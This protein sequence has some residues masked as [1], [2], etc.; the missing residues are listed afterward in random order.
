[1]ELTITWTGGSLTINVEDNSY[2]YE[3]VMGDNNLHLTFKT[4]E[5]VEIPLGAVV[6]FQNVSYKLCVP[7]TIKKQSSTSFEI[8]AVFESPQ[9]AL[10]KYTMREYRYNENSGQWDNSTPSLQFSLTATPLEHL[11]MIRDNLNRREGDNTWSIGSCITDKEKTLTF[12]Y[13]NVWDALNNLANEFNTEWRIAGTVLYLGKVEFNKTQPLELSYGKGNGFKSGVGR[14][15]Y[16]DTM[17]IEVLNVQGT[18]R[19]IDPRPFSQGG[20]GSKRL[21]LPGQQAFLYEDSGAFSWN[22]GTTWEKYD[23]ENNV[24]ETLSGYTPTNAQSY[25]TDN[26]GDEVHISAVQQKTHQEANFDG[27]EIYPCRYGVLSNVTTEQGSGG[28]TLYNVFDSS[29]P[30]NLNYNDCQIAGEEMKIVFQSGMLAGR[31][32]AISKYIH[33]TREF[34]LVNEEIDGMVMPEPQ[35]FYPQ[36]GDS[37]AIFG[38]QLPQAYIADFETHTG[39]SF[40]ML[41]AAVKYLHENKNAKYTFSGELDGIFAKNQWATIGGRL[42]IG[43]YVSFTDSNFQSTSVL[44]RI[45]GVKQYINNPYSPEIE[46]SNDSIGSTLISEVRKAQAQEVTTEILNRET[47]RYAKRRF[48]DAKQT[49]EALEKMI[50][51][52]GSDFSNFSGG[53]SPITVQTMQL[54]VGSENLQF[55]FGSIASG[56]FTKRTISATFGSNKIFTIGLSSGQ[57]LMHYTIGQPKTMTTAASTATMKVWKMPATNTIG[58][59]SGE[60]ADKTYYIYAKVKKSDAGTVSSVPS[61]TANNSFVHS[62]TAIAMDDGQE[63]GYY[64]FLVGILNAEIEEDRSFAEMFGYSE[65]LPNRITTDKIISSDG[66]GVVIDLVNGTITGKIRFLSNNTPVDAEQYIGDSVNTAVSELRNYLLNSSFAH[67]LD[68]WTFSGVEIYASYNSARIIG[69]LNTTKNVYQIVDSRINTTETNVFTFSGEVALTS[70]ATKG[71]TNFLLRPY[72]EGSRNGSW[73]GGTF[74]KFTLDGVEYS[75]AT[76]GDAFLNIKGLGFKKF[77][78]TIEVAAGVTGN[79]FFIYAR[80]FTGTLFFRKLKLEKGET[81]TEWSAAPEDVG[82]AVDTANAAKNAVDNLEIGGRNLLLQ[83]ASEWVNAATTANW[84]RLNISTTPLETDETYILSFDAK[85][86]NGTDVFYAALGVGDSSKIIVTNIRPSTTYSRMVVAITN[87][88]EFTSTINSVVISNAV[89]YGKGNANN[90]GTLYVKNIKLEK[91][92]VATDWT[93]AP[94]DV[95]AEIQRQ[96][97][98]IENGTKYLTD[99]MQAARQGESEIEGGLI[100]GTF[101][102]VRKNGQLQAALNGGAPDSE[103][104]IQSGMAE[105]SGMPR[106]TFRV[107]ADGHIQIHKS[108]KDYVSFERNEIHFYAPNSN[109]V[110]ED[111]NVITTDSIGNI[112]TA[113]YTATG[114]GSSSGT[115]TIN[116]TSSSETI[117]DNYGSQVMYS[118][119]SALGTFLLSGT[120]VRAARSGGVTTTKASNMTING[121]SFAVRSADGYTRP[122]IHHNEGD[123]NFISVSDHVWCAVGLYRNGSLVAS[124]YNADLGALGASKT[125]TIPQTTVNGAPAGT[126]TIDIYLQYRQETVEVQFNKGTTG[127]VAVD[128]GALSFTRSYKITSSSSATSGFSTTLSFSFIA[129]K[130]VIYKDG[131]FMSSMNSKWFGVDSN[132]A[133][134]TYGLVAAHCSATDRPLMHLAAGSSTTSATTR[135]TAKGWLQRIGAFDETGARFHKLNMIVLALDLW[136]EDGKWKTS[137]KYPYG[138]GSVSTTTLSTGCVRITHN[139]GHTQYFVLGSGFI[140]KST[141]TSSEGCYVTMY[142]RQANSVDLRLAN[143]SSPD[144]SEAYIVFFDFRTFTV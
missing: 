3:Q 58:P 46:M 119:N 135:F 141:I 22:G 64:H 143:D 118:G 18:D 36:I 89:A 43:E 12:D 25:A 85:T 104:I 42:R 120:S 129:Y 20:Y 6:A 74:K 88:G 126:F 35:A 15:N 40:D 98:E 138:D 76:F 56:V 95:D 10:K 71:T 109:N 32:F 121:F 113:K 29:I 127:H 55:A 110:A 53:I 2:H 111:R 38:I 67:S 30:S 45:I 112:G 97:E 63:S 7:A 100:L 17:P 79:R 82:N 60:L 133:S 48:T 50:E 51:E 136:Y 106:G 8:E 91:G 73:Y 102:G 105:V 61:S 107:Y 49:S 144:N 68:E 75:S 11:K 128:T 115:A 16:G 44:I 92:T 81:A 65:I 99:A 123:A 72:Y 27:T 34:Q 87:S 41:R 78:Y 80:D 62:E 96:R 33:S 13:T 14:T 24:W 137:V 39:A 116:V 70:E 130:D 21:R 94:E 93:P 26:N 134:T 84:K 54:L 140:D 103:P 142:N 90:T 66:Q 132:A 139:L 114:G 28:Q 59:L 37:Y 19:N 125:V 52:V 4:S 101:I 57:Y 131:M 86:S 108:E 23:E 117:G 5:H 47:I 69:A 1:M 77:V 122:T 9:Y 31:E 83:S 124:L